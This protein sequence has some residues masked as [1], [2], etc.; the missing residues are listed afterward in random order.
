VLHEKKLA[1]VL[2]AYKAELTLEHTYK[3]VVFVQPNLNGARDYYKKA[4][5]ELSEWTFSAR[6]DIQKL[7]LS[8]LRHAAT[9]G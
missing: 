6:R 5:P 4:Q 1:I 2:P 8:I 7:I 9:I 3:G